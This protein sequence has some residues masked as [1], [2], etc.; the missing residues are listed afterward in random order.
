[1]SGFSHASPPSPFLTEYSSLFTPKTIP[2][3]VLDLAC[4]EGH[5]GLF[6]ARKG[7]EV[8]FWDRS[9]ERVNHVT[10]KA[11]KEGLFV[12]SRA[13][14]LELPGLNPLE[15]CAFGAILVFRYLHRPLIPWLKKALV[16][17]GLLMYETFTMDQATFGRP[18]NPDYLLQPGELGSWFQNWTIIHE[19][20]GF[21]EKP[22]RAI[23]QLLCKKP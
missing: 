21:K 7:L 2:G 11:K 3:P 15:G 18:K 23:A 8:A 4:G 17:D 6:L 14:N 10:R 20:E 16:K 1:M 22:K 19:F 13:V 5:N 12:T 9:E